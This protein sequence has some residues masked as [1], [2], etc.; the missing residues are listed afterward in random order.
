MNGCIYI[1]RNK[2]NNKVYIGQ[3]IQNPSER[4]KQHKK[5]AKSG[6]D[7]YLHRAMRRYGI[8]NFFIE[9]LEDLVE[10][11]QLNQKE[12]Q[13]ISQFN[14]YGSGYNMNPGGQK[15]KRK[16]IDI[17]IELLK[18]MYY[19]KNMSARE[20]ATVL[21]TNNTTV[22]NHMKINSLIRRKRNCSLPDKTSKVSR[23]LLEEL[24]VNKRITRKEL[25]KVFNVSEKTIQRAI[26]R[27]ALVRI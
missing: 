5:L 7:Q 1:I 14:S 25:A 4:F 21:G 19:N 27:Y 26:K 3:T 16:P 15:W 8:N 2:I 9:I 18:N 22:L 6:S 10:D 17:N 13:Y 23:E 11:K 24:Y 20:I 12:E